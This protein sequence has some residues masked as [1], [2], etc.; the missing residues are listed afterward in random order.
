[1]ARPS[2]AP[3]ISP[4]VQRTLRLIEDAQKLIKEAAGVLAPLEDYAKE[5]NDLEKL[6]H[7]IKSHWHLVDRRESQ[8]RRNQ[9]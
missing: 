9:P 5:W 8:L 7:D 3:E 2:R 6:S 4:K 1:M